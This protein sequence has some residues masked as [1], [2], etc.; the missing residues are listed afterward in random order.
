MTKTTKSQRDWIL[1]SSFCVA[2]ARLQS[3]LVFLEQCVVIENHL[4]SSSIFI[5]DTTV[6]EAL[7]IN[8]L[9]V[10]RL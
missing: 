4:I 5:N 9:I 1:F 8:N 2:D 6:L 10:S 7:Y 3:N